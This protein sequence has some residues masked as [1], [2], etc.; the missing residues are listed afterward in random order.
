METKE[1][2]GERIQSAGNEARDMAAVTGVL[3]EGCQ[4]ANQA[5]A[6]LVGDTLQRAYVRH[7]GRV[8]LLCVDRQGDLPIKKGGKHAVLGRVGNE[9]HV[10]AG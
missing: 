3:F 9:K 4:K 8:F 10:L 6:G 1:E 2:G 7:L 5:M